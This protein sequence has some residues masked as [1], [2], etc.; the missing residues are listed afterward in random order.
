MDAEFHTVP[1]DIPHQVRMA[2][3]NAL[4]SMFADIGAMTGLLTAGSVDH[5]VYG[6]IHS[7]VL[8]FEYI[9]EPVVEE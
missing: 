2:K 8:H 3:I 7:F 6:R 5:R 4:L 9:E 1:Y